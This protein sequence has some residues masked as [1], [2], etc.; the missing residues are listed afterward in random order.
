M[1]ARKAP[2]RALPPPQP[3][4]R[5][6]QSSGGGATERSTD[7]REPRAGLRASSATGSSR[8]SWTTPASRNTRTSRRI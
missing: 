1:H 5:D 7:A 6:E 8:R 2:A 4:T 3:A